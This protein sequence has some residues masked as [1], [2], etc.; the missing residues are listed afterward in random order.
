MID[1]LREALKRFNPC[2]SCLGRALGYGLTGLENRER[3]RAIKLYLGMRAHLEGEEETLE[4]LAR[5]GLEEAAAV[6]DDPPEPEPCGVCRGVLDRVDEFAE[7]VACELEGVEFRG[8]VVGSRWPEEVRGA[9][10]ELWRTLGVEGEPIK[11]EFNREVGK[12]VERLLDARAD[13][14]D[15]DVEVVFD[16]RPSLEDPKFEV[17]VR[18]VYVRGRYLKLKRGIPQTKWPCPR[19]RGA[20][21]PNCDFTGKLY[22]ESVEELIGMI[23]KDAFLAESHKFHAAGR[24][25]IDVRM[26]GNGRPFVMELLYPKRRNVDLEELEEEINREVGDDVRVVGLEYGGPEDVGK[27]KD[28]SERS[29]KRYRA[30][31]KFEERV[32][33]DRLK[34][35]LKELEGSVIEQRT[36]RRVLHRRADKVRRKRVHEAKLV[37]YDGDRAVVEFLCDPGLYVKELISG[38]AGRTRPSLAELVEVGAE[39]ERLDVIEFL[40]EGGDVG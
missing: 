21:C 36:P 34:E 15:P 16:F 1:R 26:L 40:D 20:G 25:D 30:W 28:L 7:V 8:F 22:T 14:K 23:L 13:P 12:R 19:C 35:A 37:E 9:E 2:D 11:R 38:D 27:V 39:C 31:V 6:L 32:P 3:G 33:E 17:H 10:R 29:R 18:P 4:L 5:S 24:E